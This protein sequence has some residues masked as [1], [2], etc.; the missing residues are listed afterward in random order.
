M[1]AMTIM[2]WSHDIA[3]YQ[4]YQTGILH[5][6]RTWYNGDMKNGKG[7][8]EMGFRVGDQVF[9][10]SDKGA[11]GYILDGVTYE[12]TGI[13]GDMVDV[14]CEMDFESWRFELIEP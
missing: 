11:E 6:A 9:C 7:M 3:S 10:I 4:V 14:G 13:D 1:R 2:A 8:S 5:L 12:I